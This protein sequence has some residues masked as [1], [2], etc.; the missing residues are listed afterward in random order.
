MI[1]GSQGGSYHFHDEGRNL[2]EQPLCVGFLLLLTCSTTSFVLN[3]MNSDRMMSH[4]PLEQL[5][6]NLNLASRIL[7]AELRR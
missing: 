4:R 2:L 5:E 6:E 1:S 3:D 7:E